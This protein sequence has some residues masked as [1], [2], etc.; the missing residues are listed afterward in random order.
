E[1]MPEGAILLTHFTD[2]A[3]TVYFSR[4][5]GLITETGGMLSHGAIISREYGI[6]AV[7]AVQ[8]AC[9]RIKNG[10]IVRLNGLTGELSILN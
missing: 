4:I 7:L 9:S 3:W 2:P 1:Q 10:Q 6:P 8:E 5:S